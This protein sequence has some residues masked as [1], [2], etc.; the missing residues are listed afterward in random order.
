MSQAVRSASERHFSFRRSLACIYSL[1]RISSPPPPPQEKSTDTKD[2]KH[3]CS[4]FLPGERGAEWG[5]YPA[6]QISS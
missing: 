5:L 3:G 6:D 2:V 1:K 4:Q